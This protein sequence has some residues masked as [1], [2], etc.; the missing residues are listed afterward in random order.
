MIHDTIEIPFEDVHPI[1]EAIKEKIDKKA[2]EEFEQYIEDNEL[3]SNLFD[4]TVEVQIVVTI[5]KKL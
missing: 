4:Y 2:K 3:I 5:N 1:A